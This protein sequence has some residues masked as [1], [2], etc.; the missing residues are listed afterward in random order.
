MASTQSPRLGTATAT[1]NRP[2]PGHA[3]T[4][5]GAGERATN[6]AAATRPATTAGGN[7]QRRLGS[8]QP[9]RP[10]APEPSQPLTIYQD[11]GV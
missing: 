3:G 4:G 1:P 9:V 10:T 8:D 2:S 7:H 6:G 5:H 11:C